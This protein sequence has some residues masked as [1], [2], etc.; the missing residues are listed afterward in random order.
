MK[1]ALFK[2]GTYFEVESTTDSQYWSMNVDVKRWLK[3][4]GDWAFEFDK[5]RDGEE[6]EERSGRVRS[7]SG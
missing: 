7:M 6:F 1:R 4:K 3:R 5:V 2:F